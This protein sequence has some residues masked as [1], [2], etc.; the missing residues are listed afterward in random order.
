M[1]TEAQAKIQANMVRTVAEGGD[2]NAKPKSGAD[3]WHGIDVA[4][5][6]GTA[7]AGYLGIATAG[8]HGTAVAGA[9]GTAMAGAYGTATV[10]DF[11]TATAGDRGTATAGYEGKVRAGDG[12]RLVLE[13]YVANGHRYRLAVAYVGEGGIK[14]NTPYRCE[15]GVFI[16]VADD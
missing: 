9:Y 7:T 6:C 8:R 16:E 15:G 12:G 1:T 10:G 4:G 11:G 13:Y 5:H 2:V 14:P 3:E